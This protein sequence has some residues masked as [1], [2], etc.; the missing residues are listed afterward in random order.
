MTYVVVTIKRVLD[1]E[2][3]REYAERVA[4]IANSTVDLVKSRMGL[5][6]EPH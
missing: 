6:T 1:L 4:P 2:A 5:Y 3:F